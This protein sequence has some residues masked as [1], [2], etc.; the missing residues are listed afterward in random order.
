MAPKLSSLNESGKA[1]QVL[2]PSPQPLT[3]PPAT[4]QLWATLW[5]PGQADLRWGLQ[6]TGDPDCDPG[7]RPGL[8]RHR[9]RMLTPSNPPR[10]RHEDPRTC[11]LLVCTSHVTGESGSCMGRKGKKLLWPP[12]CSLCCFYPS[13]HIRS[14]R[15]FLLPCGDTHR[16]PPR[17]SLTL[18]GFSSPT[19][20]GRSPSA[21]VSPLPGSH[22][23]PP[24]LPCPG[25]PPASGMSSLQFSVHEKPPPTLPCKAVSKFHVHRGLSL[26]STTP[27]LPPL[28][29]WGPLLPVR[30]LR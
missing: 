29:P 25:C 12:H 28:H 8:A 19:S 22:L 18:P 5:L 10:D 3:G 2:P 30:H 4:T 6:S 21:P 13:R 27:S 9:P 16:R 20:A 17:V 15:V 26:A 24:Q 11:H 1:G 14:R 7:A 23:V